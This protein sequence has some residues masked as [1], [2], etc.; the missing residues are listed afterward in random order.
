[1]THRRDLLDVYTS[2]NRGDVGLPDAINQIVQI[3]KEIDESTHR[4]RIAWLE[5][6]L[7]LQPDSLTSGSYEPTRKMLDGTWRIPPLSRDYRI[8]VGWD[9]KNKP[10]NFRNLMPVG[11]IQRWRDELGTDLATVQP[12]PLI[13]SNSSEFNVVLQKIMMR[14]GDVIDE[15]LET[16]PPD[17]PIFIISD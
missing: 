17:P 10:L 13:V 11:E 12:K 8:Q 1:M 5:N 6:E 2:M 15:V 3:F 7:K 9:S 14:V 16:L 4:Q